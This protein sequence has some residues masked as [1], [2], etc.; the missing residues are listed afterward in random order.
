[1]KKR[2]FA[3]DE[4]FPS[5]SPSVDDAGAEALQSKLIDAFESAVHVGMTPLDALAVILEWVSSE[6]HRVRVSK[7]GE[8]RQ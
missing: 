2:P 7:N 5:P 4:L 1:M 6:L 3:I 8:S